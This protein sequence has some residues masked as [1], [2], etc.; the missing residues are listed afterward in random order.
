MRIVRVL[1][2]ERRP[3]VRWDRL[4]N[5]VQSQLN[6]GARCQQS[7]YVYGKANADRLRKL[8][9]PLF[10]I[11]LV[12][13][14]PYPLGVYDEQCTD[15]GHIRRPWIYKHK[16]IQQAIKDHGQVIYC[17]WDVTCRVEDVP[18]AFAMVEHSRFMLSAFRYLRGNHH[19]P[20]RKGFARQIAV[21]GSWIYMR[22]DWLTVKTIERLQ[23]TGPRSWH[24]EWVLSDMVDEWHNGWPGEKVWLE[25][26]ES[27]IMVQQNI[28][29]PWPF[30]SYRRGIVTR[31]TIIPFTWTS[32]FLGRGR[33]RCGGGLSKRCAF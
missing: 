4:W 20:E 16:L 15:S 23:G 32:L 13:P 17:D 31:D 6:Q 27:P 24:D 1:W 30:T 14:S 19:C 33:W 22:D 29:S 12:D 9:G 11:V 26:Y 3:V 8:C 18:A 10:E 21:S 25:Q 28:R 7:V 2:G 5:D